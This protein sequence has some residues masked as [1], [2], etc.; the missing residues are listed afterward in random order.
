MSRSDV[1]RVSTLISDDPSI[2]TAD[3]ADFVG[4]IL[5]AGADPKIRTGDG[6]TALEIAIEG[7]HRHT[8]QRKDRAPDFERNYDAI[9]QIMQGR[10][11]GPSA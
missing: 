8:S 3:A 6:G 2:H 11:A 4:M 1:E 7:T 10:E 5:A 9:I